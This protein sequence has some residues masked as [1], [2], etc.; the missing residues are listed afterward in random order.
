ME[1]FLGARML[2]VEKLLSNL[3]STFREE[4]MSACLWGTSNLSN[5]SPT[6]GHL[7]WTQI[8][9]FKDLLDNPYTVIFVNLCFVKYVYR[10]RS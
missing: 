5:H 10:I 6:E 3:S 9:T 4:K 2:G 8:F 1:V 7:Y